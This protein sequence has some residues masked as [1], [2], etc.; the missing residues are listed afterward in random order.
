MAVAVLLRSEEDRARY[1][2]LFTMEANDE[3]VP[4]EAFFPAL[5]LSLMLFR[6][7]GEAAASPNRIK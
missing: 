5:I 6:R 2:P 1:N 3:A 7:S 4:L